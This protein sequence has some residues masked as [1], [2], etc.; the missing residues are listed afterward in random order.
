M[1]IIMFIC[2]HTKRSPSQEI[3]IHLAD[4]EF[5]RFLQN[6]KCYYYIHKSL[7]L[8]PILNHVKIVNLP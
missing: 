7:M 6:P 2:I 1:L 3:N 5:L 4:H 8:N